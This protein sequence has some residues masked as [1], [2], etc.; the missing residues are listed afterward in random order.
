MINFNANTLINFNREECFTFK[1]SVA[2]HNHI[3]KTGKSG[4]KREADPSAAIC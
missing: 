1:S 3:T 4:T 2:T